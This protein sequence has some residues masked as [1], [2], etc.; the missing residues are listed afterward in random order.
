MKIIAID[1]DQTNDKQVAYVTDPPLT[2]EVFAK[3]SQMFGPNNLFKRK[4]E[5]LITTRHDLDGNYL[6]E[7][8]GHLT[9]MEQQIQSFRDRGE[10]AHQEVL[11]RASKQSGLPIRKS[12]PVP[13]SSENAGDAPKK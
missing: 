8:A 9:Q 1:P 11:Q 3:Y 5:L 4:G 12:A 7:T 13:G 2:E 6:N 10:K